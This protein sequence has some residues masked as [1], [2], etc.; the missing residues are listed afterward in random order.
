[1]FPNYVCYDNK[2]YAE[3]Q[4]IFKLNRAM[5]FGDGAFETIRIVNGKPKYLDFHLDRLS[6]ALKTLEIV[7]SSTDLEELE[8]CI[9][10]LIIKNEIVKGGILR[11]IAQR[12]GLGKYTPETNRVFFYL[13]T[14][15]MAIDNYELN[16]SGL[17]LGVSKKVRVD[18]T[19][20]SSYKTLNSIPYVLAAKEKF[21]SPFDE[22]VLLNSKGRIAEATA[23]NLFMVI[24][25]TVYFPSVSEGGVAGVMKRI[26][27]SKMDQLGISFQEKE[28]S[29]SDL[30]EANEVFISNSIIGINWISSYE[31]KRYFKK[32]SSK[33]IEQ[34]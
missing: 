6:Q 7:V 9:S 33:L 31:S 32:I 2:F 16:K 25:N 12:A 29:L 14:E 26:I 3:D 18:Y 19:Q 30:E 10:Q 15:K 21:E 28:L 27:V 5:K 11:V 23:S 22:L 17:K 1:M 8:V 34:L 20:F 13:E 4:P 24:R